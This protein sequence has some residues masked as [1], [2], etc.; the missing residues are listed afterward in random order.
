SMR[1]GPLPVCRIYRHRRRL[2]GNGARG[3]LNR[4][5]DVNIYTLRRPCWPVCKEE[6][7]ALFWLRRLPPSAEGVQPETKEEN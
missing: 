1:M 5:I 6:S 3:N 4:A 7:E 2:V